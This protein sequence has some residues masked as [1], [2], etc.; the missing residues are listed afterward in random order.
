[1]VTIRELLDAV[2]KF[3]LVL[4]EFQREFVWTK[5]Q[6]KSLIWSLYR[7][8]P[9]GS[10]LFWKTADPPDIKHD[11]VPREKIGSVEVILDGQQRL[12]TL[13][14]LIED[15]IPPYYHERDIQNDP[16]GLHFNLEEGVF[17]YYQQM[18][19]RDSRVW[20]PVTGCFQDADSI[21]I[22]EIAQAIRSSSQEQMRLAN[23]LMRNLNRLRHVADMRYP[24]QLV[25]SDADIDTAI[26]VFDLVNSK[27]TKL[28]DSDLALAHIC[29]K[30][31]H[32]RRDMKEKILE[33]A[34]RGFKVNLG[35]MVRCLTTIVKGRAR[36]DTIH[37]IGKE[38][39][40]AGWERQQK[41]MDY[42]VNILPA[43][44]QIHSIEDLNTMNVLV[45]LV[46]YCARAGN[47]FASQVEELRAIHWL[48]AA[49]MWA[50]YTSQ[51]DSRL[52]HDVSIVLGSRNPWGALLNAIIDQRGRIKVNANDL[53]GRSV[54]HPLYRMAYIVA[55][56]RGA[57]DWFNGIPLARPY[58]PSYCIHS[59][60]IFP[61]AYL[62]G[63]G[64]YSSENH[65]HVK[66]VNEIANR[67]F[68]TA[69][70][71]VKLGDAPPAKCLPEV[72]QRYPGALENQFVPMD[73][74]LWQLDRYE[75]FLVA[76]RKLIADAINNYMEKLLTDTSGIQP[77]LS[78]DDLLQAGE[79][80]TLEYKS[81][82]RWDLE[83]N[84][85][86]K[87]LQKAIAKTVAGFFNT[88]GGTLLVGVADDGTVRGIERDVETLHDKDTDGF[89]R[90]LIGVLS[91]YLGPEFCPY[92]ST[93]F[94][95]RGERIIAVVT[96]YPSPKPV[97]LSDKGTSEFYIRSG[98]TTTPLNPEQTL[99]YRDM[100]WQA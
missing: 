9:T 57:A 58:G 69:E 38:A 11:A 36:F 5:E 70:T 7:E 19:M 12:T 21:D 2:R 62:Y 1:L 60:H 94:E 99:E 82:L 43:S 59:H 95:S 13:Y 22:F 18:K 46:G 33:M 93:R 30:W 67:A 83:L 68:L 14:L 91:S 8:Y 90:A 76:R 25:P 40:Q 17:E 78:L 92:V 54:Q 96:V 53:E 98:S 85:V 65:M 32:A 97:F 6:A 3:D 79:S 52:D 24:I 45:P 66:L 55:K 37:K 75:D 77:V 15:E 89:Y 44:A 16:R 26:D 50:R 31:P 87:S 35:F 84:Q 42:L 20:L 23:R 49:N 63:S 34:E 88:E 28:K 10:L 29:G 71:N 80:A 48:Y 86:N 100:H 51:T 61:S 4:P 72:Q 56:A 27:G 64:K 81:S 74:S 41:A 47:S 39:L 73:S